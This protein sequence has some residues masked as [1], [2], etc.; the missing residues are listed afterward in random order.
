MKAIT[1][2]PALLMTLQSGPVLAEEKNIGEII[3][4]ALGI[5][6]NQYL[7]MADNLPDGTLPRSYENG[8][9]VTSDIYWWCSGFYPGTLWYLYEYYKSDKIKV[10]AEKFTE[11]LG[12]VQYLTDNH[13]IGFQ[14]FCSFGNGWRLTGKKEYPDIM[15]NAAKSLA[16]RFNPFAGQIKSWDFDSDL[17]CCPV[18]IDNLMNLELLL[19]ASDYSDDEYLK[20]IALTHAN[21]SILNH[22]RKD[23][24]CYHLVDYYPEDGSIR[25]KQT[26]QGYNDESR[27]ARGQAW[28]LYGYTMLYRMTGA[29]RYLKQAEG[30]ADLLMSILPR[31]GIP[32][33]D[34][35]APN[36]PDEYKDASAGA[37]M[38]SALIELSQYIPSKSHRYISIAEKQIRTLCSPEYL[39]PVGSNG[40]FI[41]KH[42][43]GSIPAQLEVDVPLTYADYYFVEALIR[44]NKLLNDTAYE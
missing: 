15:L 9:L 39:A 26:V 8:I 27:W 43:V 16:S 12:P 32:Y 34:F 37:I 29:D 41:L 5:A 11:M 3:E 6:E 13:D 30:I 14:I 7:K 19:W 1:L 42:S 28:A 18:I 21:V 4:Y 40:N 31:D 2:I 22:F 33:W 17:Y 44:M 20:T 23:Y 24:S 38:A 25:K 10:L 36:I 35:D